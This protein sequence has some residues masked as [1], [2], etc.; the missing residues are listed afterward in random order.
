MAKLHLKGSLG[1]GPVLAP[2]LPQRRIHSSTSRRGWAGSCRRHLLVDIVSLENGK[3]VSNQVR[4]EVN[5][6]IC[7]V[8]KNQTQ[9]HGSCLSMPWF[10]HCV[11]ESDCVGVQAL[12]DSG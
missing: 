5:T 2:G 12:S 3:N 8:F 10:F 7:L 4:G 9:T 11:L 6:E 1:R